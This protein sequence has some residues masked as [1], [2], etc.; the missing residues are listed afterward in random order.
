MSCTRMGA[1]RP[2]L[3]AD[4]IQAAADGAEHAQGQHVHLQQ[5]HGVQ[6]V[7]VPLDDAAFGHGG[8]FH[9]H[10]PGQRPLRQ[11]K[12]AHM[13]AQVARKTLQLLRLRSSHCV[14]VAC[15]TG[16]SGQV[17]GTSAA[18]QP[19]RHSRLYMPGCSLAMEVISASIHPAP[20]PR[21]AGAARAVADG[22]GG[23]G[24]ALAPVFGI[25]VLDDFFAPLV[26][27]VHINVGRLVALAADEALKQHTAARRVHLGYT[28]AVTHAEL[29]AEPRPGTGCPDCGQSATMSCT[30]KKYISYFSSA[31]SASSCI[32]WVCTA[33]GRP[34]G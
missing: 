16:T 26:F 34:C 24:G 5:T 21:H 2:A 33:S 11:H 8:V 31:I 13:L 6:V 4:Q 19:A 25:D 10:Q 27:K 9:R 1:A 18:A 3:L 17:Q 20:A 23:E 29:A 7:L 22:H 12:T 15:G 30:V 32:S 14:S 28:Q